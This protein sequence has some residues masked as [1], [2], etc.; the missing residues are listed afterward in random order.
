MRL[1]RRTPNCSCRP[2]PYTR[3]IRRSP[4]ALGESLRTIYLRIIIL[5]ATF[6]KVSPLRRHMRR[7]WP[8][9]NADSGMQMPLYEAGVDVSAYYRPSL[10]LRGQAFV[11]KRTC[12]L[13]RLYAT[14]YAPPELVHRAFELCHIAQARRRGP[15]RHDGRAALVPGPRFD[16]LGLLR[17]PCPTYPPPA[18]PDSKPEA[19]L[20]IA[21]IPRQISRPHGPRRIMEARGASSYR[22]LS[23]FSSSTTQSEGSGRLRGVGYC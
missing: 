20:D 9:Y 18:R 21:R 2:S 6:L 10:N 15:W 11:Y 16:F 1:C 23:I 8:T 5:N 7:S 17:G 19:I 14:A 13:R 12:T 3:Q 22:R 4:R